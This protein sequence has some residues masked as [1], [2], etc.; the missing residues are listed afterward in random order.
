MSTKIQTTQK[1]PQTKKTSLCSW[2]RNWYLSGMIFNFILVSHDIYEF[3]FFS[4]FWT[5]LKNYHL[6]ILSFRITFSCDLIFLYS[7][8][9]PY[10]ELFSVFMQVRN[11]IF[12][13]FS[14]I[15]VKSFQFYFGLNLR[16]NWSLMGYFVFDHL[17]LFG[18]FS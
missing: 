18:H 16:E 8:M 12:W 5:N 7:E 17:S 4:V 10:L 2:F 3:I 15:L 9:I 1:I 14:R 11:D 6:E 13:K